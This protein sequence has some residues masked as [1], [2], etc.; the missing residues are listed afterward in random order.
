[1]GLRRREVTAAKKVW[2]AALGQLQMQLPR[3]AFD[4]WLKNTAGISIED[5]T[6][7]V[8]VPD[9]FAGEWLE[10]R[11]YQ[12]VRGAAS[13]I[14][15]A[16]TEVS[17][18]IER[19]A[20]P[21]PPI[22]A[23]RRPAQDAP[24]SNGHV[25][26]HRYSFESFV[27][28]PCNSLSYNA[29]QAVAASFGRYYNPL[30]IYSGVGLGKTHLLNAIAHKCIE[31]R[32]N[33]SY[34]TSEGFTNEF[35]TAIRQRT[36]EDF[37]C[38]YRS[39]DVLLMDDIQFMNGKEQTLE[40]FFHT[41]NDLHNANRQVVIT[42]D[43]SPSAMPYL[44]DRFRSRFSWGLI[45]DIQRPPLETRVAILQAKAQE[46]GVRADNESLTCVADQ[47]YGSVRDLE[48]KFN[49]VV[50]TA[51]MEKA[52]I[53]PAL[54]RRVLQEMD[55]AE[56]LSILSPDQVIKAVQRIFK[57]DQADMTGSRRKREFVLARQA[58]M[59]LLRKRLKLPVARI[60]AILGGKNHATVV[61][62]I[63]RITFE[64]H[65]NGP[66]KDKMA[67]VKEELTSHLP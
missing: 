50:A 10:K 43:K 62:G 2:A 39:V 35:I 11:V 61:H 25:P 17:F 63:K 18:I 4:T 49:R 5:G 21:G 28:S 67:A 41:F 26:N 47:S 6:L 40:G 57:V 3:S 56:D 51:Q 38:K 15:N 22:A 44:D 58:A 8:S 37:R 14:A 66:L 29:A 31:R 12:M 45:T 46:M 27:V 23:P 34:V 13:R 53:T 59:Y 24:A 36:T 60:G 65:D 55:G 30:F 54:A 42:S 9:A 64:L 19:T 32:I 16:P 48:G 52:P 20:E 1:M 33:Y 7:T